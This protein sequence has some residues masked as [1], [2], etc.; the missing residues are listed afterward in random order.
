MTRTSF[1]RFRTALTFL[2]MHLAWTLTGCG[3]GPGN[4]GTVDLETLPLRDV[5]VVAQFGEVDHPV[6]SRFRASPRSRWG[7]MVWSTSPSLR[8]VR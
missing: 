8:T 4:P 3:P 6:L 2:G 1:R 5:D 7:R